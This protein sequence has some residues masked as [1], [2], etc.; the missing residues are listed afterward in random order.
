MVN[1]P[2]KEGKLPF[3]HN[4][5][6]WLI[7]GVSVF[8]VLVLRWSSSPGI[9]LIDYLAMVIGAIAVF[10]YLAFV[11]LAVTRNVL[12][13]QREQAGDNAYYIGLLLTFVSLS[14]ALGKLVVEMHGSASSATPAGGMGRTQIAQLIPDF[15]I[16]LVSTICGITARMI[17]QQHPGGVPEAQETT[18]LK[19]E[20]A[21]NEYAQSLTGSTGAI[22][23]AI[24]SLSS[25]IEGQVKDLTKRRV[26]EFTQ[27]SDATREVGDKYRDSAQSLI[28]KV[29]AT[30]G[31]IA[32]ELETLAAAKL[33]ETFQTLSIRAQETQAALAEM[34]SEI[35]ANSEFA[36]SV[37]QQFSELA[38]Q[39]QTIVPAIGIDSL[40]NSL[41]EATQRA[42][43]LNQDLT[44]SQA[45][46]QSAKAGLEK[47]DKQADDFREVSHQ[48][49]NG[50]DR[51]TSRIETIEAEA[52]QAHNKINVAS[53]RVGEFGEKLQ[54]AKEVVANSVTDIQ[55]VASS[56][57]RELQ[58]SIDELNEFNERFGKLRSGVKK[59]SLSISRLFSKRK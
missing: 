48:L 23:T 42:N 9:T 1:I 7:L 53:I 49:R 28:E 24:R 22:N 27:I 46:V 29:E 43:S 33:G 20:Q 59:L 8:L 50:V 52:L 39:M 17:L 15:G 3:Q 58:K 35:A 31:V 12:P 36:K 54:T 5:V 34:K 18:Q 57:K 13:I 51:V 44:S 38:N 2:T 19:L 55:N 21:S 6:L 26:E 10:G 4:I 11:L 45:H 16:A 14:V 30:H 47:L 56:H 41:D 37:T 32:A 40:S 25:G